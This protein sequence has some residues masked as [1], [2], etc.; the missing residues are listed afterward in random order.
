M[1]L[2]LSALYLV[3]VI[4]L[5]PH[6]FIV[7]FLSMHQPCLECWEVLFLILFLTHTLY[8]RYLGDVRPDASPW[9]FLFSCPF[10]RVLPWSILRMVPN[11]LGG[12]QPRYLSFWWDFC[13]VVWFRVVFLF[14]WGILFFSF[15]FHLR[16]FNSFRF[17]YSQV[18]VGFHFF[19]CSDF[20]LDL[21]VLFLSSYV[22]FCFL[23]LAR[24]VFLCRILSLYPHCISLL[25]VL[26]FLVLSRFWQTV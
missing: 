19:K 17:Q 3:A 2:V 10:V 15:L 11:I 21:A 25:A 6:F 16:M 8:L 24:H 4:N 1:K 12:G 26:G 18:F 14:S 23:L 9:V 13:Y 22:V 5:P 7:Q 20:F